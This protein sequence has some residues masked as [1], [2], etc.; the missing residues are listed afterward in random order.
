MTPDVVRIREGNTGILHLRRPDGS[1]ETFFPDCDLDRTRA[2]L[3]EFQELRDFEGRALRDSYWV[4]GLNWYPSTVSFLYWHLFYRSVQYAPLLEAVLDGR[5]EPEFDDSGGFARVV[6]LLRGA[7]ESEGPKARIFHALIALNNRRTLRRHPAEMLFFRFAE[8]DFRSQELRATLDELGVRYVEVVPPG[9]GALLRNLRHGGRYYFYG[10]RRAPNRFTRKFDLSRV[11]AHKTRV[12][13]AAVRY[14]EETIS[15]YVREYQRHCR[16]LGRT[17]ARVFYGFDDA[18]GYVFPILLACRR[19]GIRT[20]A[21]QH[22]AYVRRHAAYIMEGIER[23][24]FTWFEKLIVWGEYWR[25]HLLSV[26]Q[27]HD[28][29]AVVVGS[30]RM[31]RSYPPVRP[32]RTP[33]SGILIPYEFAANTQK[34]GRF[35]VAFMDLGY[36]VYFK[37]RPDEP[38]DLQLE[39]YCLSEEHARKLVV[40][41]KVDDALM[42]QVDIVAGTMTT[43]VYE[44][45]PYGKIVWI[46]DTEY[47]HLEDL[48]E[49]GLAHKVRLGDLPSLGPEYFRPTEVDAA[50]FF[51]PL[52]LRETIARHVLE[53]SP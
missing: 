17:D 40:V 25:E 38:L 51:N 6:E 7:V 10:G 32:P 41:D 43:L 11:G 46:L 48:V 37:P 4:D 12:F 20:V 27:I 30:N 5:M 16:A 52:P 47:K 29:E 35:I 31:T 49:E 13:E 42:E 45:L 15:S 14:V 24:S 33:P 22:G 1:S 3:L 26:S 19:R 28:P 36:T 8:D 21:H 53:K 9:R 39:G 44:L 18:N 23:E 34:V 50:R 2:L